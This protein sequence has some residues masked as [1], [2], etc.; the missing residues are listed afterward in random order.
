MLLDDGVTIPFPTDSLDS[1]WVVWTGVVVACLVLLS[2]AL[3]KVFGPVSR[4]IS[5]WA[6]QKRRMG[7]EKADAIVSDMQEELDYVTRVAAARLADIKERDRL[8][9]AHS[10]WDWER[11][12]DPGCNVVSPPP[13][14]WP[15]QRQGD[16]GRA[17][18]VHGSFGATTKETQ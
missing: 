14:L 10:V 8:N 17:P 13:P 7:E 11:M 1:P 9:V 12:N 3:P 15:V 2:M 16:P 18:D 5:D 4:V 6:A